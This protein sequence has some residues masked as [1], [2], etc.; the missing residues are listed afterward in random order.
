MTIGEALEWARLELKRHDVSDLPSLDAQLL[1]EQVTGL[2]RSAILTHPERDLSGDETESLQALV[3]RLLAGEPLPYVLGEWSFFGLSFLVTP[4][5]LIPRPETEM[6][7]ET[8]IDWLKANPQ[9]KCGADIGT[10]SG[11]IALSIL[12]AFPD[13]DLYFSA[14]DR[15]LPALRVARQNAQ[16]LSLTG[17]VHCIQGNLSEPLQGPLSLVCANL[18]YIPSQRCRELDVAKN[19][20]LLA[21]DGGQ[22]GFELYR[23]L[24]TDLQSKIAA[25]GLILCEIEYSQRKIALETAQAFF[26]YAG[27]TVR[28]DLSGMPR[29]LS[30]QLTRR[31]SSDASNSRHNR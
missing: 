23:A 21:L 4:Q 19:E 29:L 28:D 5:V 11:C 12:S 22:D 7:V 6:L 15:S 10:G 2:H 24:F 18:P 1:L 30:I 25:G 8:A 17:R 31:T 9:V 13:R 16:R 14:T 27:I 20:P 26:P 3:T